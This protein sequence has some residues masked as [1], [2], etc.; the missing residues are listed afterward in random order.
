MADALLGIETNCKQ[1][2]DPSEEGFTL[3]DALL[4]IETRSSDF[5]RINADWFH[6]G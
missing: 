1:D 4:G 2:C 6:F 3:A 5:D